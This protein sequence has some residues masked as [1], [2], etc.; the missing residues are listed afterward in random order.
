MIRWRGVALRPGLLR[1]R[2]TYETFLFRTRSFFLFRVHYKITQNCRKVKGKLSRVVT[3]SEKW[4][5]NRHIFQ[6]C[7][8]YQSSFKTRY[9][10]LIKNES[11]WHIR[12]VQA[13]LWCTSRSMVG[14]NYEWIGRYFQELRRSVVDL[15]N[16]G[17]YG[18][19]SQFDCR[20]Y[21]TSFGNFMAWLAWSKKKTRFFIAVSL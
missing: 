13:I 8:Q 20:A 12:G 16:I 21:F 17:S 7:T 18:S 4:K 10:P 14:R 19:G 5:P 6:I 3:I 15:V 2:V 9:I 11:I 1:E